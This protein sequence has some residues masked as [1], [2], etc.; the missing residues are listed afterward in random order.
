MMDPIN[1]ISPTARNILN[2]VFSSKGIHFDYN[3]MQFC[4]SLNVTV[5]PPLD[6][7][8]D[9]ESDAVLVAN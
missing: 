5:A 9:S 6:N 4:N 1:Q 7:Y 3:E 2:A 8:S